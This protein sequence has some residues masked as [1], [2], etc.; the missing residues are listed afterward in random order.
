MNKQTIQISYDE[1]GIAE[2]IPISNSNIDTKICEKLM[3][4]LNRLIKTTYQKEQ[5]EPSDN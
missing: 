2:F 5:K 3:Q 4:P 1:N